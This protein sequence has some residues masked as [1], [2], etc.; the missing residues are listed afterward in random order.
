MTK[1]TR[2]G[3]MTHRLWSWLKTHHGVTKILC[4]HPNCRQPIEVGQSVVSKEG[5][6]QRHYYH[7]ACYENSF[8]EVTL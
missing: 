1:S 8:I 2:Y 5:N 6:S 3:T 7:R 4:H